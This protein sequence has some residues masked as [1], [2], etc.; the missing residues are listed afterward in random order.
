MKGII[1][2]NNLG[3]IDLNNKMLWHSK[4]DFK[5]FKEKTLNEKLL[6]GYNT[7]TNLPPL[8]N[9]E[10]ILDERERFIVEGID[11]CI[12]GKK[13]YEKYAHLFTELH[14]SHID[15]NSIGDIMFPYLKFLNSSCKVF[16]YHFS[17]TEM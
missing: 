17:E 7:F 5:H 15:N 12:G 14:I 11:W 9:R 4:E 13:T 16:N 1:A 8:K 2:V 10:V 6:V 3:Y